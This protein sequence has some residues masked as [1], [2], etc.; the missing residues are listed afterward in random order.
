MGFK[1]KA[2][3]GRRY[4]METPRIT[5]LRVK[6]LIKF[7]DKKKAM[8]KMVYTDETWYFQKGSGKCKEWQ[9]KDV[10]SCSTKHIS[11]GKRHILVH[12]GTSEG[13]IEGA[14]LNYSSGTKPMDG[15]DYHSE[16]N[17]AIM[18]KY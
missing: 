15:D 5:S 2:R 14:D 3:D 17:T 18:E 10:R 8:R 7:M 12:A 1:F 6:F 11:S 4:L 13:F 16:V 9:D